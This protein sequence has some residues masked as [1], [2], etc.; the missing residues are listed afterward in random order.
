[1][2]LKNN[3]YKL[4][5]FFAV[6]VYITTAIVSKGYYHADEQYQ[7]IEFSGLKLG[8]H[9]SDE[10]AMKFNGEYIRSAAMPTICYVLFAT[11][12]HLSITDPYTQTAILRILLALFAIFAIHFF[13]KSTQHLIKAEYHLFFNLLSFFFWILPVMNVRFTSETL[14]GLAYFIAVAM[15][16]RGGDKTKYHYLLIGCLLGLSF[17]FRFQSAILSIALISWLIFIHK[18]ELKKIVQ[19]S[20]ASIF[21]LFI[22][23]AIDSWFYGET[24]ISFLNYWKQFLHA[25]TSSSSI[26]DSS[27]WYYYLFYIFKYSIYPIGIL[28]LCSLIII[29]IKAPKCLITWSVA[30]F[31]IIHS[32]I[33][34]KE[35][36]FLF[37]LLNFIPIILML[38]YQEVSDF[39][40]K[41]DYKIFK[42][43][44][45][46]LVA[47]IN[48]IGLASMASKSAGVGR[49]DIT[50][51]I[52]T[53]YNSDSVQLIHC[54]WASPYMPW[55]SLPAKYYVDKNVTEKKVTNLC[56]LNN[57]LL[58][59]TKTNLLVLRKADL[60]NDNCKQALSQMGWKRVRQSI[61]YWVEDLNKFYH[62]FTNDDIL[63]LYAL[64]K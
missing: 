56:E 60:H 15:V 7:I 33:Q 1:M 28:I 32:M 38:S 49:M 44:I 3:T 34:H 63:V 54:S 23:I 6:I 24:T 12:N 25:D 43:S 57:S 11:L 16:L 40:K 29:I 48:L 2:Q 41:Y 62:Y 58:N 17:L 42:K 30:S 26:F 45:L 64:K 9:I 13:I 21:I 53:N 14:S 27:P 8:T 5:L 55:E 22:G 4:I 46:I 20:I 47:A 61:P 39:L 50:N 10:L 18:T 52:H 37:P 59:P 19:I 51:Y 31:I 35:E 36:R